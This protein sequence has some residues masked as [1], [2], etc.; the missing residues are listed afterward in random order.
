[1]RIL[2]FLLVTAFVSAQ[3]NAVPKSCGWYTY[4]S[5]TN[6]PLGNCSGNPQLT[7]GVTHEAIW[8]SFFYP[9][10]YASND[11]H[12]YV[13]VT[14]GGCAE[15]D[16][17]IYEECWP[18]FLQWTV[19]YDDRYC[20]DV[21]SQTTRNQHAG[22]YDP[23]KHSA[24]YEE[25]PVVWR[26][27]CVSAGS[28]LSWANHG[29]CPPPSTE[30]DCQA[31]EWYWNF[32]NSTCQ[33]SPPEGD[34]NWT[35]AQCRELNGTYYDNGCCDLTETP[36]VIDVLGNGFDF[37]DAANGVD[38]DF[39]GDGVRQRISWPSASSDDS[40]LVLDRNG[41][42]TID[43]GTELFGNVTPQSQSPTGVTRN[44]FLALAEYD[45]PA[46]GGNGDG[47]ID[48][49]DAIFSSLRLW[50]D[51]NHNGISES[52]ELHTLP[53]LG[54]DSLSLDYRLS[55]RTDEHGNQFRYRAKVDDAEHTK[56]GC[57]AWDVL[58]VSAN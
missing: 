47:V 41:N 52:S 50:Q 32:T 43:S 15:L 19:T 42:G 26:F 48:N 5:G 31:S 27:D 37:T 7:K 55:K 22:A 45:K 33:E 49:G 13:G 6:Y 38:F 17:Y 9:S 40:W 16:G 2:Y 25:A 1:M 34:C 12:H 29:V 44:G 24:C 53:A 23:A 56:A 4:V 18:V 54:I 14:H 46:N 21:F 3:V 35:Y 57:W 30:E 8:Y 20:G 51:A 11:L 10:G 39:N 36:I 28:T 58:L